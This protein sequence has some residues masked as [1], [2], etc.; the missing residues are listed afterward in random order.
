MTYTEDFRH[1]LEK[2]D[3]VINA[4][5]FVFKNSKLFFTKA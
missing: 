3:E 2:R 4:N 5:L 1:I